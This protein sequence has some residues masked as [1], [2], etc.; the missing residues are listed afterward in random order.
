MSSIR[1]RLL[2]W[3]LGPILLLNLVLAG[4]IYLLAWTPAQV[5]FDQGLQDTAAALAAR[6][7]SGAPASLPPRLGGQDR[8]WFVVRDGEGRRLAGAEGF[9]ALRPG[10]PAYDA[11]IGGEP[12]RVAALALATPE[13]TR[14]LGVA[15]TL[16]QRAEVRSAILRSLFVLVTLAT[17]TLVGLVWL[18]VSNG[19]RPLARIRAELG[20]R[21]GSDLAPLPSEGV[22][23]EIAPVVTGF[24]ELLDR[25]EAGARAQRD[26]LADMAHQLRTPLAGLQLQLEWLGERH[27]ADEETRRSVGL[28]RLANERMIRQVNQLLALARAKGGQPGE[29]FAALDLARLVQDTVQYF[30]EEAARRG[31]DIGFE[32][33]PAPVAGEAFQ[34]RDLIDNLVDN[35]LRYT[36]R[37]GSVTVSTGVEG[38]QALFAVDDTGPGIPPSRRSQVFE[39]FVRLDDKTAGSGLGLAIVRDIAGAHRARIE[40]GEGP[41]GRGT[42]VAVRFPLRAGPP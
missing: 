7:Q 18:S 25:V 3:L 2:K 15:R 22:P 38:A 14:Q 20:R 23:Y 40:L 39:R 10:A 31:I 9:P 33:A 35:A 5:A 11:L 42:R 30:V 41:G 24:N 29:A 6:L 28:M 16:R 21:G 12:V 27:A 13:G 4:L 19:L 26:F 34:L 32:L 1:L 8:F 37:G 17:L 36:P